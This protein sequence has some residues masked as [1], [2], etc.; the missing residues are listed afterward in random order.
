MGLQGAVQAMI[1]GIY[2]PGEV[3]CG[4]GRFRLVRRGRRLKRGC[5]MKGRGKGF[6][7]DGQTAREVLKHI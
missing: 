2:V 3:C 6:K 5:Y 1:I 7:D 4:E